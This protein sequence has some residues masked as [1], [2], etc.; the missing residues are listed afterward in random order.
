MQCSSTADGLL[1][2]PSAVSNQHSCVTTPMDIMEC[3]L[4]H[5][6]EHINDP[7]FIDQNEGHLLPPAPPPRPI[8]NGYPPELQTDSISFI[9][10]SNNQS[11]ATLPRYH[12]VSPVPHDNLPPPVFYP[13]NH[14]RHSGTAYSLTSGTTS[15]CSTQ[16][17]PHSQYNNN[18][19]SLGFSTVSRP[20][21]N[22]QSQASRA[23]QSILRNSFSRALN[24]NINNPGNYTG[25]NNYRPNSEIMGNGGGNINGIQVFSTLPRLT[26][27]YQLTDGRNRNGRGSIESK[28]CS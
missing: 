3:E 6:H 15:S 1:C 25:N 11:L 4:H 9:P 7:M 8:G 27:G 18:Q 22:F 23:P 2:S 14:F 5:Y 10:A 21:N 20:Q 24:G 16:N 17:R 13:E 26:A 12:R 28:Y 19:A